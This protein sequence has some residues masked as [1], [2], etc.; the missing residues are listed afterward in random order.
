VLA[1]TLADSHEPLVVV[2]RNIEG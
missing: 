2:D 1:Q